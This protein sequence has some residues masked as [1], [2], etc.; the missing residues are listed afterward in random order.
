MM[1]VTK[2]LIVK[3]VLRIQNMML[4]YTTTRTVT[5]TGHGSTLTWSPCCQLTL[6][7]LPFSSV[8]GVLLG[9]TSP[10]QLIVMTIIEIVLFNVNEVIGR[11]YI[12]AVDCGDTI[13]VHMFGAYF[14]LAIS[15]VLYNEHALNSD[16]AGANRTSDLFSMVGTVFLWM[17]WPSFNAGAAA[18]GD[19]QMRGLINTYLS[20]CACCM[21][22]F[23]ASALV[24][25]Q[26]KFCMEHIQNATLAGG[27]AVG[28]CAD[29]IVTPFGSIV[30][31]TIAGVLST[32]GY[33]YVSPWLATNWK[34]PDTCG[35][36]NLHGMPSILGGLLSVLLSALASGEVYEQFNKIDGDR[37]KSSLHEI[38]PREDDVDWTPGK[39]AGRQAMAMLVTLLFAIVG[40]LITGLILR[41]IAKM[42][43]MYKKGLTVVRLA[44]NIGNIMDGSVGVG[45]HIPKEKLFED[46]L[47]FETQEEYQY[48][49]EVKASNGVVING[50]KV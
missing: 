11:K 34:I 25:P 6:P 40:G 13:F 44:L 47:F 28:A 15:R 42:Q 48:E 45:H 21:S 20:L 24:N 18:A 16:K 29:M 49:K 8:F 2:L 23:A 41:Q 4:T 46:D 31:G 22:A 39:Q 35:V 50:Y 37:S 1:C 43:S 27:V 26:R 33:Q 32:F 30:I 17:F 36:N 5:L 12:G 10:I 19:A 7:Q 38:F 9:T 14:G 3:G